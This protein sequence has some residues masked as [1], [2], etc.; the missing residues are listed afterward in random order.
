MVKG[1]RVFWRGR[2]ACEAD[3]KGC[4]GVFSSGKSEGTD[5]SNPTFFAPSMSSCGCC[6][7]ERYDTIKMVRD[8]EIMWLL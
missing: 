3:I 4:G 7:C 8:V 1:V 5:F 6:A 2:N